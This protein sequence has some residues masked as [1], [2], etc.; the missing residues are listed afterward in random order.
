[1]YQEISGAVTRTKKDYRYRLQCLPSC[2][3]WWHLSGSSV[4]EQVA[5]KE[6]RDLPAQKAAVDRVASRKLPRF[7]SKEVLHFAAQEYARL[8]DSPLAAAP[9][10]AA[11][12]QELLV[13]AKECDEL[14]GK[15]RSTKAPGEPAIRPRA[16]VQFR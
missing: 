16:A 12:R 8:A 15:I 10:M 7:L 9:A 1:M 2:L 11:T 14:A 4:P 5:W 6:A 3:L 13:L